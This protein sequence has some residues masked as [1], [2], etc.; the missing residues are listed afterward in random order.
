MPP[1]SRWTRDEE[2]LLI[3]LLKA[4]APESECAWVLDRSENA[5]RIRAFLLVAEGRLAFHEITHDD[6]DDDL[7]GGAPPQDPPPPPPSPPPPGN[8]GWDRFRNEWAHRPNL[9]GFWLAA[10]KIAAKME[11]ES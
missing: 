6:D 3:A 11:E 8:N 4:G 9:D 1:Y 7:P 2:N 10:R 5:I